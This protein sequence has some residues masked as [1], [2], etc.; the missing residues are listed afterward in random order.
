[1]LYAPIDEN[2]PR[3]LQGAFIPRADLRGWSITVPAGRAGDE[4]IPQL[5]EDDEDCRRAEVSDKLYAAA[6]FVIG[7]G[8][9]CLRPQRRFRSARAGR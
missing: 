2:Q 7:E 5:P 6:E 1:M 9:A 3:R 8:E 4:I